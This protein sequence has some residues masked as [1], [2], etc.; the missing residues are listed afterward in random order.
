MNEAST[1]RPRAGSNFDRAYFKKYYFSPATRVT[2][3]AEM[4]VRADVIASVLKQAQLPVRSILDAGCGIGLMRAAFKT[5]LPKARYTGLEASDYLC[6][7]YGWVQSSIAD[8][9]PAK[10]FDLL[11]CYDVL[12]YLDDR[13]AARAL[14]NF[15]RL[16]GAGL[17][18]SALTLADWRNNCDQSLTDSNV[19]LRSGDWYRRR[20]QRNFRHLGCGVWVRRTVTVIRWDLES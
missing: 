20:L 4:Q 6:R 3:A 1:S 11:V 2:T 7:R 8:Y 19:H 18:F 15:A 14:A 12:Q 16:T 9:R 10:P 13:E 5:V 17:Y